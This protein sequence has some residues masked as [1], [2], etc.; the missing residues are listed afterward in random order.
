MCD[1]QVQ[2]SFPINLCVTHPFK[3]HK[4]TLSNM[5]PNW[6]LIHWNFKPV[7]VKSCVSGVKSCSRNAFCNTF[8]CIHIS[9]TAPSEHH[10]DYRCLGTRHIRWSSGYIIQGRVEKMGHLSKYE[11][12]L[13]IQVYK[14]HSCAQFTPRCKCAL[15]A[16]LLH[17][18]CTTSQGEANL[19][20][21]A[22]LHL[23]AFSQNTV[24]MAKIHPRCKFTPR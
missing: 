13:Y 20:P 16:N 21:D 12:K 7:A 15:G 19:H 4:S 3:K 24:Y 10:A 11:T 14:L 18:I 22:N 9:F 6:S 5:I 17:Q 2:C 23:G 1:T 8:D